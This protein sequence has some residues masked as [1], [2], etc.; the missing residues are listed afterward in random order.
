ML[1]PTDIKLYNICQIL[2]IC[3]FVFDIC[4]TLVPA[5]TTNII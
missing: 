1:N 5:D 4:S 3:I 2:Q